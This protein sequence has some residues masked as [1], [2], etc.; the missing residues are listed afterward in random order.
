MESA[1][2][3]RGIRIEPA[4]RANRFEHRSRDE[5]ETDRHADDGEREIQDS[6]GQ[7]QHVV[8]E[9]RPRAR[10]RQHANNAAPE[11]LWSA[12]MLWTARHTHAADG[13]DE[14]AFDQREYA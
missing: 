3:E 12:G 9:R 14:S 5:G 8:G 10:I 6:Q 4:E 7:H 13:L 11:F 1:A 2:A